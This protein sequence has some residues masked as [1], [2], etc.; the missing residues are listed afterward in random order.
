VIRWHTRTERL[1]DNVLAQSRIDTSA[2]I[3]LQSFWRT[4]R[5]RREKIKHIEAAFALQLERAIWVASH[6]AGF[7]ARLHVLNGGS[8]T[9]RERP[10][11]DSST[12]GRY[13]R[14]A[15]LLLQCQLYFRAAT[16]RSRY[17]RQPMRLRAFI[18]YAVDDTCHVIHVTRQLA[19]HLAAVRLQCCH[20]CRHAKK[21]CVFYDNRK[22][23]WILWGL[24]VS[25][26]IS[27]SYLRQVRS[28]HVSATILQCAWRCFAARKRL[29]WLRQNYATLVLQCFWRCILA[30]RRAHFMLFRQMAR[31]FMSAL[32]PPVIHSMAIRIRHDAARRIQRC[33]FLHFL[34]CV[35]VCVGV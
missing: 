7:L 30:Y 29:L 12:V 10:H 20:R 13:Y 32:L 18:S 6:R 25:K 34:A 23:Y 1:A 15:A 11:P 24:N 4:C 21:R 2:A 14:D 17:I 33:M 16:R 3:T 8:I 27:A 28:R 22:N 19:A 5:A 31:R 35:W 26:H 9:R